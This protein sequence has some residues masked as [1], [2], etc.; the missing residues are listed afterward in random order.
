MY[1]MSR[2]PSWH[3]CCLSS[4]STAVPVLASRGSTSPEVTAAPVYWDDRFLPKGI[5]I[6]VYFTVLKYRR[7]RYA[8]LFIMHRL[9]IVNFLGIQWFGKIRLFSVRGVQHYLYLIIPRSIAGIWFSIFYIVIYSVSSRKIRK[10]PPQC[11][12]RTVFTGAS[13]H[14]LLRVHQYRVSR[15]T[16]LS[17]HFLVQTYPNT[18]YLTLISYSQ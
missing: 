4:D 17:L 6:C 9:R 11:L 3:H 12:T 14:S 7:K 5:V 8:I 18:I 15:E 2:C 16:L 1:W 13:Q 10:F